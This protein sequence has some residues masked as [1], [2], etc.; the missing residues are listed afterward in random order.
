MGDQR[1]APRLPIGDGRPTPRPP[2]DDNG[3]RSRRLPFTQLG[4]ADRDFALAEALQEQERAF[5]MLTSMDREGGD[6]NIGD[7]ETDD[8]DDDL[9]DSSSDEDFL[10]YHDEM[11]GEPQHWQLEDLGEED[12]EYQDNGEDSSDQEELSYEELLALEEVIGSESRGMPTDVIASLPY[13]TY[14][15]QPK[16]NDTLTQ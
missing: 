14:K 16:S 3:R 8:S 1:P 13:S 7:S 15:L 2:M 10:V 12:S 5:M 11:E 9:D 6:D 4:Q